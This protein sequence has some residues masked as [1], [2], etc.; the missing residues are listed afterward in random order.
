MY[1]VSTEPHSAM[2]L[3]AGAAGAVRHG[4]QQVVGAAEDGD[5]FLLPAAVTSGGQVS[6]S[7][8]PGVTPATDTHMLRSVATYVRDGFLH[9]V[10][11]RLEA[12]DA[13]QR[14]RRESSQSTAPG[15]VRR[16]PVGQEQRAAVVDGCRR[17]PHAQHR[18]RAGVHAKHGV[19]DVGGLGYMCWRG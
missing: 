13:Q 8:S 17:R 15:L 16:A 7:E 9:V 5:V 4:G 18:Q 12:R 10:G 2:D 1:A 3:E 14:R 11:G 6:A 19:G